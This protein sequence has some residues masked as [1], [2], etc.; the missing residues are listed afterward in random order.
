M[1]TQDSLVDEE[2]LQSFVMKLVGDMSAAVSVATVALGEKMGL[3]RAMHGAGPV[4]ADK[5]AEKT[6]ASQRLVQEWLNAQAAAGYITYDS[7]SRS[8]ELPAE[9][10]MAL[11]DENSP[12]FLAGGMDVVAA[13]Y[14]ADDRIADGMRSGKGM[15]WHE[16]DPRLFVGTERFFRPGYRSFLTS[17]W[18]PA[19]DGVESRLQQGAKVADVG[20]GLGASTIIMA[21]A[22]PNSSFHGYDYHDGSIQLARER[23]KEAGISSNVKFDK[24]NAKGYP[25]SDYDLIC[26]FDCLH[27]MGDPVGA[28]RH[29]RAALKDDGAV[30]LVEPMAQDSLDGNLH[31]LGAMFYGASTFLCTPNAVNQGGTPALGAQAGEAALRRVFEEAGFTR[32]R[33]A[34]ETPFNLVLE[35]RP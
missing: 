15:G 5:L 32:F 6:G 21:Q 18:I 14:R 28:A 9:N 3:Y 13:M 11:A 35:A 26:F 8:Y 24:A 27:D 12:V 23:A 25:G 7:A 16:H 29:A 19:L 10:A 4:T 22:Y 17:Q 2:K 1:Q 30:L 20:C 34:T 31:P 33:R